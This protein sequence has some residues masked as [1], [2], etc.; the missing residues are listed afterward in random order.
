[1]KKIT[2]IRQPEKKDIK[3]FRSWSSDLEVC[4]LRL[5]ILKKIRLDFGYGF[6]FIDKPQSSS[7]IAQDFRR[8]DLS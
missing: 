8:F 6:Y 3:I 1:M 5:V 7:V 4:Y 2:W